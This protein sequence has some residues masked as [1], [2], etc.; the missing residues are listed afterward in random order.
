MTKGGHFSAVI[1]TMEQM[2]LGEGGCSLAPTTIDNREGVSWISFFARE[3]H[4]V[5]VGELCDDVGLEGYG[6]LFH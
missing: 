1:R 4:V 5:A 6:Y 2:L 3:C